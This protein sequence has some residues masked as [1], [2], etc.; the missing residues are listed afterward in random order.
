MQAHPFPRRR[1]EIGHIEQPPSPGGC[2][3]TKAVRAHQERDR[4]FYDPRTGSGR[5]IA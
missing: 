1:I 3:K 2:E 5:S 4:L